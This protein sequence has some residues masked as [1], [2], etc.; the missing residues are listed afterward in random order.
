M[1]ENNLAGV[2]LHLHANGEGEKSGQPAL[3]FILLI[4]AIPEQEWL[5]LTFVNWGTYSGVKSLPSLCPGVG[6]VDNEN[7]LDEDEE[8]PT[9]HPEVHP[10]LNRNSVKHWKWTDP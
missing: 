1:I 8:E 4:V 6:K 2:Q 9:N 5:Y 7:Q 3:A 10:H